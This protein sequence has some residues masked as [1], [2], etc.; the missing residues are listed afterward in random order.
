MSDVAQVL[1]L[2]QYKSWFIP[3]DTET[4]RALVQ[5]KVPLLKIHKDFIPTLQLVTKRAGVRVR[6]SK[7]QDIL[8][9]YLDQIGASWMKRPGRRCKLG[10]SRLV[11]TSQVTMKDKESMQ[12]LDVALA[13]FFERWSHS[14]YPVYSTEGDRQKLVVDYSF[15]PTRNPVIQ[16]TEVVKPEA[17]ELELGFTKLRFVF[18]DNATRAN[19]KPKPKMIQL[20]V[21]T[22][23]GTNWQLSHTSTCVDGQ[24]GDP[25]QFLAC[26]GHLFNRFTNEE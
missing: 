15:D 4:Y 9:A 18:H 23:A 13:R 24:I 1:E 26:M 2:V 10:Q 19:G 7:F 11:F 20:E 17:Y 12:K 5:M 21:L 22:K 25:S 16:S 8:D 14:Y 6:A 3:R